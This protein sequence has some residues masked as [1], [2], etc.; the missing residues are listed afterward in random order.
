MKKK[1]RLVFIYIITQ[2][3]TEIKQVKGNRYITVNARFVQKLLF[4]MLHMIA[5][6]LFF[7]FFEN[8]YAKNHQ[9]N[10]FIHVLLL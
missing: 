4:H 8:L 5:K 1:K 10:K 6:I 7:F 9:I 2:K 3:G